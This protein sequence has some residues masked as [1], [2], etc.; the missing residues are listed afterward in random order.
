MTFALLVFALVAARR[1]ERGPGEAAPGGGVS[2][3]G[4]SGPGFGG[5]RTGASGSPAKH[6]HP[7]ATMPSFL[8][9]SKADAAAW[10]HIIG[11]SPKFH[12]EHGRVVIGHSPEAGEPMP[13]GANPTVELRMGDHVPH[14]KNE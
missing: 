9:M 8:Q 7:P 14:S 3:S 1:S 13:P 5:L 12:P 11:L 6:V 10:A 4:G 2:S